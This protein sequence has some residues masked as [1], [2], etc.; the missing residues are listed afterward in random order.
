MPTFSQRIRE[1]T[2]IWWGAP[3]PWN[4][5]RPDRRT[6]HR[7]RE[8]FVYRRH[9]DAEARWR[10]CAHWQRTLLN[11]W[12]AREFARRHGVRVPELY[13]FGR[14]TAAV[15]LASL[16]PAF[17]IRPV[18]GSGA[19]GVFVMADGRELLHDRE[20]AGADLHAEL[21]RALGRVA[22]WPLLVEAFARGEA[23]EYRLPTEYKCYTFA[24][25][26]GA[27]GVIHRTGRKQ[28]R[29]RFYTPEWD[30]IDDPMHVGYPQAPVA[31][32]PACL[33]EILQA[34]SVLGSA[35]GTFVR[36]DCFATNAGAVFAEFSATPGG[37]T[38]F[39]P[40]ADDWFGALWDAAC[41]AAT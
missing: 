39:T 5:L 31:P 21:R 26:V 18:Q 27:I 29:Q 37:G 38:E 34:A 22:R 1:R 20:I 17:V 2:R 32:P 15:P 6:L 28:A 14:R 35:W 19:R 25:R 36:V 12:N 24:G 33:T 10:C 41:P 7:V 8:L 30:P 9:D 3:D 4:G 40:Y 11:K 16:P 13:W 23:G